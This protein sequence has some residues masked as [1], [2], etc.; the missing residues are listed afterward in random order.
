MK[1]C[2][3]RT[4]TDEVVS[5]LKSLNYCVPRIIKIYLK[6]KIPTKKFFRCLF[7]IIFKVKHR[8]VLNVLLIF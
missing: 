8:T 7:A 1:F 5:T 2:Y 3:L 6:T 4:P